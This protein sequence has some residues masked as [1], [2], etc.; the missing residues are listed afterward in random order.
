VTIEP[1][2]TIGKDVVI[3]E[4]T[5]IGPNAV[6]M[7]GARIGKNCKYIRVQ[8]FQEFPRTLNLKERLPPPKLVIIRPS[9]NTLP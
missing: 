5:W 4:G 9:V 7:D 6:I 8:L 3:G 2:A 1:F